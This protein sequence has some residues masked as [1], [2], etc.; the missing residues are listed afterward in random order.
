MFMHLQLTLVLDSLAAVVSLSLD[1]GSQHHIVSNMNTLTMFLNIH[2]TVNILIIQGISP[3][4]SDFRYFKNQCV[5]RAW[6]LG[7][8]Q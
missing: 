8:I 5:S 2:A 1:L 3:D 4:R 7:C 6:T